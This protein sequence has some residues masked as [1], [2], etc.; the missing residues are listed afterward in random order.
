MAVAFMLDPVQDLEDFEYDDEENA[1]IDACNFARVCDITSHDQVPLLTSELYEYASRKTAGGGDER[2]RL[3]DT[4]PRAFR[5]G[6]KNMY[7]LLAKLARYIFAIP[8]S[9]A[10]SERALSIFDHMHTKKRNRLHTDKV[11]MLAYVYINNG[12]MKREEV[13]IA[14]ELSY[15]E[16]Y[17]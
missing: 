5:D 6:R 8:T 2:H 13:N 16:R 15:P 4:D 11:T 9:S 7:P 14:H 3:K 12:S 1:K 17:V 10:V